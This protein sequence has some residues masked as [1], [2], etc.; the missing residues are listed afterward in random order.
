MGQQAGANLDRRRNGL[1][2][3]APPSRL[4]NPFLLSWLQEDPS[5]RLEA[6][7]TASANPFL[8]PRVPRLGGGPEP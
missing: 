7:P 1:T 2:L 4:G 6:G 3:G 5:C 8:G